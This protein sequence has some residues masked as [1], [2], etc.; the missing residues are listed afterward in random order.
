M[1]IV[2]LIFFFNSL[3]FLIFKKSIFIYWIILNF[4]SFQINILVYIDWI[5]LI[6]VFTVILISSII[7]FYRFEY[8][9]VDKNKKRFFFLIILFVI[10]IIFIIIRPNLIRILL[11][12]DGLGLV[13]YCLVIYYQNKYSYRSGN[14]TIFINRIGDITLILSI[15]LIFIIGRWNFINLDLYIF[16]NILWE[17]CIFLIL[18]TSFTKRA[19]FPFSAWLP[20]AI[21]APTPVSSLVHSSTLVTAGIYLLIRFNK[22]I[23]KFRFLLNFILIVSIYTIIIASL[24]AL[25]EF[26]F[27]KIIA[28]STLRQL[29][30]IMIIYSLKFYELSYFHLITHAIFKSMIF[31]RS[32]IFIHSLINFQD[33]RFIGGIK[34]FMPLTCLIFF[35]S[36]M[37]LCGLPFLSGFFSKEII[38]FNIFFNFNNLFVM[39]ISL[40]SCILTIIYRMRLLIYLVYND[41]YF[42][43]YFNIEDNK[44]INFS[45]FILILISIIYGIFINWI[46]YISIESVFLFIFDKLK[47]SLFLLIGILLIYIIRQIK[48]FYLIYWYYYY[49]GSMWLIYN[50][51]NLFLNFL[52]LGSLNYLIID[53]GLLINYIKTN[54]LILINLYNKIL[55]NLFSKYFFLLII[56]FCYLFILLIFIY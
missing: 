12:W 30:L 3:L 36:N 5:I 43:K 24:T 22:L 17:I 42:I 49:M 48:I 2:S 38:I 56:I 11:G 27:K 53:K 55:I 47:I 44:I 8:I 40:I 33:I 20:V 1:F 32:G 16:R 37:S 39:I 54:N 41:F 13:S 29:G 28:F 10:S 52:K 50:F 18:I 9:I 19:Q 31:I 25:I 6:F 14:L 34:K 23:Y 4:N 45:I 51:I 7:I 21:A 15:S 35:I 46:I 26:D